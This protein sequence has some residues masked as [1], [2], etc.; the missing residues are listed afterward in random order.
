MSWFSRFFSSGAKTNRSVAPGAPQSS[1]NVDDAVH[2]AIEESFRIPPD[3][4]WKPVEPPHPDGLG[5]EKRAFHLNLEKV[6]AKLK[7]GS[8]GHLFRK[9]EADPRY[10][11]KLFRASLNAMESDL[12]DRAREETPKPGSEIA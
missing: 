5:I 8:F 3:E 7:G 10:S 1:S 9:V 2:N 11:D 12:I 4:W 6:V